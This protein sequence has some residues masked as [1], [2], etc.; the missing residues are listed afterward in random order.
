MNQN[1]WYNL[2]ASPGPYPMA[3]PYQNYGSGPLPPPYDNSGHGYLYG[4]DPGY[5]AGYH[6]YNPYHQHQ[7]VSSQDYANPYGNYPVLPSYPPANNPN[8]N[9]YGQGGYNPGQGGYNSNEGGN[10]NSN[11]SAAQVTALFLMLRAVP[12]HCLLLLHR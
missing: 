10:N 1:Y 8:A 5:N 3:N 11:A 9:Y 4:A 12:F 6:G 7:R 2:A